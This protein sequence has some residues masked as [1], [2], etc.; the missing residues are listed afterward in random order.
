MELF[1]RSF[2]YPP[3]WVWDAMVD[4]DLWT[5]QTNGFS[6]VVGCKYRIIHPVVVGNRLVGT[7]ECTVTGAIPGELL[8]VDFVGLVRSGEPARW[9]IRHTLAGSGESTV[10]TVDLTGVNPDDRSEMLLLRVV[11]EGVARSLHVLEQQLSHAP[12]RG[13]GSGVS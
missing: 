4:P 5:L 13:R 11:T 7:G 2:A 8:M 6:P 10:L 3:A 1:E 12:G 9:T